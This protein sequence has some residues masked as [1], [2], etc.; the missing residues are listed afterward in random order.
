MY[1]SIIE[2]NID[3]GEKFKMKAVDCGIQSKEIALC[4]D[5]PFGILSFNN[6]L[7]GSSHRK[8]KSNHRR[9]SVKEYVLTNFANFTGKHLCWRLFFDKVAGLQPASF[10]KRDSETSAFL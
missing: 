7:D 9:C 2:K 5:L 10:L 1:I 3:N 8:G 6:Y 4:S